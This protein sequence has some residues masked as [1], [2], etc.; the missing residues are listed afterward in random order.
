VQEKLE[1]RI[2]IENVS[3]YCAPGQAMK[4]IDF[5]QQ[6]LFEADCDLLRLV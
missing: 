4:E 3:Y 6:V 1:R 5:I 2:A